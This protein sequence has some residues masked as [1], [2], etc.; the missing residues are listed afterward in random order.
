MRNVRLYLGDCMELM[1]NIPDKVV[2]LI[3]CDLP[4]GVSA[5]KWDKLIPVEKLWDQYKRVLK[6]DGV[7]LLFGREPFSSFLRSSNLKMY[8]YDWYWIK[9]NGAD[10]LNV[11]YKPFN[12]VETISIFTD[13][14]VSYSKKNK[15][16]RYYPQFEAG[17]AY[18]IKSGKQKSTKNNSTVR[19]EIKSIVTENTGIRYPKNTLF[20][21]RDKE[22]FHS[23]QKPVALLEYLIK[24]YTTEGEIVLDNCM[25]SGSTGV[26]ARNLNRR[27]IGI[28]LE[29]K[30]FDIA[31]KRINEIE[32]LIQQEVDRELG[33]NKKNSPWE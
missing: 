4:Y 16:N 9:P 3:L 29:K 24:T 32:D 15:N 13:N 31:E 23:T 25:G 20:F 28:E 21:D 12:V 33:I 7:I 30:Y 8:K 2:D 11:K 18:K 17:E 22:K 10:F 6:D 14:P 19:S 1:K 26:A 27:F 5:C